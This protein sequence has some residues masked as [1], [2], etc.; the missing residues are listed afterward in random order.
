MIWHRGAL[1]VII[2]NVHTINKEFSLCILYTSPITM[3]ARNREAMT[4]N[5]YVVNVTIDF[6]VTKAGRYTLVL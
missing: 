1:L 4:N 6:Y 2:S 5:V 3:T